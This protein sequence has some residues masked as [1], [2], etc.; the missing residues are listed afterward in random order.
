MKT[1]LLATALFTTL[2]MGTYS[3]T[4]TFPAT[5]S[6]GI[7]TT[8]P[9]A[10]SILEMKSTTQGM[11]IPRMTLTQRNNIIAPATGLMIYQTNSTPGFYYYNGSTW[12]ALSP[13]GVNKFLSNLTAPTAVNVDLLPGTDNLISL[14]SPS[15]RW[16][17]LTLA[18][19]ASINALTIGVG[20]GAVNSNT[21]LGRSALLSNTTGYW[22]T[23]TGDS[24]LY[25]NTTG[26]DNTASG[27][28]SL[29]SNT[30]G[31]DNTAS[32]AVALYSNTTGNSN[33]AIGS[34]SLQANT[35]GANNTA[36]GAYSLISN[37]TGLDNTAIGTSSLYKNVNGNY[38]TASGY[39]SLYYNTSGSLNTASGY[40]SLEHNAGGSYNAASGAYSLLSNTYG[41][42]N[43]A[44]GASSLYN[45][46]TGDDN[47]AMGLNS[48]FVNTKGS[49][50]TAIGV[51]SLYYN[52]TGYGNTAAGVSALYN[53]STG[54]H[55]TAIGDSAFYNNVTGYDNTAV[56]YKAYYSHYG[57]FNTMLGANAGI[58]ADALFNATGLGY[59]AFVDASNKVRIGD[60]FVTSIGG[61]VGW[62]TFSDERVKKD[63]KENVPGLRFINELRP[64]SYHY[65]IQKEN[66]LMGIKN[67][68]ETWAG[69]YDIEKINFSGL[70]AQEVDAAAKKINYDFSGVD[71]TGKILSLRYADF[72]PSLV[73]AVQE[74]SNENDDLKKQNDEQDKK[75]DELKLMMIQLQQIVQSCMPCSSSVISSTNEQAG[76]SFTTASLEQNIP[77]PF[78][79]TT[80]IGYTL[81]QRF[82]RA[83][84]MITDKEGRTLL[85]KDLSGAGKGNF[86][87]DASVLASG[88]YNYSLFV[89]AKLIATKQ[90]ILAK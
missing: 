12:K 76:I 47:T 29:Y 57:L 46:T 80:S 6:A 40:S 27:I 62:S 50:N 15:S 35:T 38:N 22:N 23:A 17:N 25:N 51:R 59:D 75:M 5:G 54:R 33:T 85:V 56:G 55:N 74:L 82:T 60:M 34:A 18:G 7:G 87:V 2:V 20:G 86:T 13:A 61:Q 81:P 14:G 77:N 9:N 89:D 66:E 1:N 84:M 32:G 72:V 64:V 73:K 53:N 58:T 31:V 30:G 68:T 88:A 49:S 28:H 39:A 4:N 70:V 63:V 11:L 43:T 48:L 90:M 16:K 79:H 24:S 3:Q 36:S 52:T 44:S 10:S 41:N 8:T 71:K 78:V 19:D 26:V 69:K 42:N 67:G 37:T 21:A 45:N 65:D 83:Q